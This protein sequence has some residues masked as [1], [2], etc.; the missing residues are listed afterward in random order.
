VTATVLNASASMPAG[1]ISCIEVGAT[2]NTLL[3]TYFN[4]GLTSVWMTTDG[5]TTWVSK[6]GNLPDMPVRWAL[7][8][9]TNPNEAILATELGVWATSNLLASSPTWVPSNSG[10]ANVRV[11][12][13]Q[14]RSSDKMVAAA[15]YGR[16]LFTSNAFAQTPTVQA[17]FSVDN[18]TPC[19][20][21]TVALTDQS[22]GNPNAWAWTV[23]PSTVTY[24]NGT[25]ATSQNPQIQFNAAGNYTIQLIASN[26][27]SS[28]TSI[29]TAAVAV[30]QL[31]LPYTENFENSA[32]RARWT[33]VNPDNST[34]WNFVT[35]VTNSSGSTSAFIDNYNY[36]ITGQ[37]D[38]LVSP[39][40]SLSGASAATLSFRHAYRPYD[41]SSGYSDS[42][43]VYVST[44]C[45]STWVRVASFKETNFTSGGT[46]QWNTGPGLSSALFA[47]A[48]NAEWCGNTVG[49]PVYASCKSVN[50]SAYAGQEIRLKFENINSYGQG[51]YLDD[52][53]ITGSSV[54]APTATFTPSATTVCA[55]TSVTLTNQS[56]GSPTSYS[57]SISPGTHSY[58]SSTSSTST[59]PVVQFTAAGTYTVQLTATNSGGSNST[60]RTITVTGLPA[61]PTG[62]ASQTFCNSGT[63][64]SLVATGSTIK[65]Y[66]TSTGGSALSTS[67]ALVSGPIY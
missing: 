16:G 5:G 3:V 43:A 66:S 8:H 33:V 58:V 36:V 28:D 62:T 53:G 41:N 29:Q 21:A 25:S 1:S 60:S 26:A 32:N 17:S 23:T 54:A 20:G 40:I 2:E 12:M 35:G 56:T 55:G 67:T 46:Y 59:S 11:D 10:L 57:W 45:G 61:A 37:R 47:P 44:N 34:T 38:G 13:L 48:T 30:G 64:A 18:P 31:G 39:P 6:E 22:L 63:V 50:L 27:L 24:V 42:M 4:Y 7:I 65:W 52:I 9:P 14:Y 19:Q 51:F 15:T 49:S